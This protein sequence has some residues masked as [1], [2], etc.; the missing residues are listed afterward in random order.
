MQLEEQ[1]K[2]KVAEKEE[3]KIKIERLTKQLEEY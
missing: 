1:E 3:I 2:Q